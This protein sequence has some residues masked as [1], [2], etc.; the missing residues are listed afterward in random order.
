MEL[1]ED[2][3]AQSEELV[4]KDVKFKVKIT[5]L[6]YPRPYNIDDFGFTIGTFQILE[7]LEGKIS[8]EVFYLGERG[9]I[10]FKGNVIRLQLLGEYILEGRFIIDPK[11][12]PQYE[13]YGIYSQFSIDTPEQARTFLE[14]ILNP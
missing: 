4:G 13:C 5:S 9:D 8:E 10:V 14:T 11:Y 12:G 2:F 7:V 6:R 3:I 1:Q